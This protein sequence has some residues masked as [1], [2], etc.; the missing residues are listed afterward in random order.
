MSLSTVC[1]ECC[2]KFDINY[3]EIPLQSGGIETVF[4]CPNC[5]KIYKVA[6]IT[7]RGMELQQIVRH[8]RNTGGSAK[9]G[10]EEFNKTLAAYQA[11][12]TRL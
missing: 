12:V 5:E 11:E 6:R 7:K 3:Y 9:Y 8:M 1:T 10:Q 2:R 4:A